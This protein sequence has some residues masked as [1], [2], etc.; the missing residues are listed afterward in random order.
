MRPIRLASALT[1]AIVAGGGLLLPA[2]PALAAPAA[3]TAVSAAADHDRGHDRY[4]RD[5]E[6][7]HDRHGRDHR[8]P[9]YGGACIYQVHRHAPVRKKPHWFSQV[10]GYV[11]HAPVHGSCARYGPGGKWR[12]VVSQDT[13]KVGYTHERYLR[14]I[15]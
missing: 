9:A 15:H 8:R 10:R 7:D 5:H 1:A 13:H 14:K 4:G 3:P 6:R 2:A 12:K 11:F